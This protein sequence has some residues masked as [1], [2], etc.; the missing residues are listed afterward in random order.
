MHSVKLLT[1]TPLNE[2][3]HSHVVVKLRER[4]RLE[5]EKRE[6][7][8]ELERKKQAAR[9]VAERNEQGAARTDDAR[10]QEMRLCVSSII[11]Q[12]YNCT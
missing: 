4:E 8:A 7:E 3:V 9:E 5:A 1:R 6:L 11:M 2:S 12:L 10:R